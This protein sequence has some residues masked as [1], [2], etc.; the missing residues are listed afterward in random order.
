MIGVGG[1]VKGGFMELLKG[2]GSDGKVSELDGG[3]DRA[4]GPL[5]ARGEVLMIFRCLAGF[6]SSLTLALL[7]NEKKPIG[8]KWPPLLDNRRGSLE[9]RSCGSL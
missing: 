9:S 4:I 7:F 6:S 2:E 3:V 5:V 1:G 8:T